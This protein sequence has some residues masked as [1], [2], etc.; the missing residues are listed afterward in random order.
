MA[1]YMN[2]RG[3]VHVGNFGHRRIALWLDPDEAENIAMAFGRN[4]LA[5]DEIM[6]AVELVRADE[7]P[8]V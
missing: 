6:E 7:D 2:S 8:D 5:Y 4:D 3:E 1:L